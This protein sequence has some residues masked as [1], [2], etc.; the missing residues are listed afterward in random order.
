MWS[1]YSNSHKGFCVGFDTEKLLEYIHSK[2]QHDG[3][4]IDLYDVIYQAEYPIFDPKNLTAE[5]FAEE[6]L[7]VKS[8]SWKYESEY[9]LISI[10][11]TNFP[12]KLPK[13]VYAEIILGCRISKNDRNEIKV[14]LKKH[15]HHVELYYSQMDD[16]QFRLNFNKIKFGK[17]KV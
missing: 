13:D 16:D 7:R 1:H 5:N 11:M 12:L 17:I 4:I 2:F 8:S 14:I 15:L 9:R 6:P 3:P 10:N